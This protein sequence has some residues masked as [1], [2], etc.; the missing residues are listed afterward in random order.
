MRPGKPLAFGSYRGIPFVGLPGNPVSSFVG[1]EVF[2]R[3]ALHKLAGRPGWRR[4]VRRGELLEEVTSDGRE[5]YLRGVVDLQ[6]GRYRIRLAGHQGSGNL[7]SLVQ[8]N[9]LFIVPAGVRQLGAGA[10]VEYWP[11]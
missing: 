11:I 1:F 8:A 9:A 7:F 5:S 3:P 6:N 10:E 4:E 2:L